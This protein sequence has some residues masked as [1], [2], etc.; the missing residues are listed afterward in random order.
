MHVMPPA[1]LQGIG[2]DSQNIACVERLFRV[3]GFGDKGQNSEINA[4]AQGLGY[5]G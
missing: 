3:Q 2:F 5:Q 4:G 1:A